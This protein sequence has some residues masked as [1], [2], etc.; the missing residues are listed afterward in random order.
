[1]NLFIIAGFLGSGKTTLLLEVAKAVSE[2]GKKMVIIE[3]EVGEVG[4]D[5]ALLAGEGLEVREIFS[6]CICCSLRAD[7][8]S[9]LLEIEREYKPDIV[10][11]E[12]SGIASPRQVMSALLGYGGEINRKHVAVIV[13]AG[14]Y[15][16]VVNADIP[17]VKDGIHCA[18]ILVINKTDLV[19]SEELNVL[20]KDLKQIRPELKTLRVSVK[21]NINVDKLVA[22]F[23]AVP[24]SEKKADKVYFSLNKGKG[25]APTAYTHCFDLTVADKFASEAFK[26]K[27][28]E[29][30]CRISSELEKSGCELIGHIKAVAKSPGGGYMAFSVTSFGQTPEIKGRLPRKPQSLKIALN[31]IVYGLSGDIV[32]KIVTDNFNFGD[33]MHG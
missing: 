33:D 7:L 14:R 32:E 15:R 3:N 31:V 8:I 20:E 25:K 29:T 2:S 12:P 26:T 17:I 28:S 22:E 6:G 27:L 21:N 10:I 16:N 24:E 5:D 19:S 1:M 11:L 30:L 9:T 23:L 4:V 18:D 13:D